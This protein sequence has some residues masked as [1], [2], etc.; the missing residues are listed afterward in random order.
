MQEAMTDEQ[1]ISA[2]HRSYVNAF[3]KLAEHCSNGAVREAGRTFAFVSGLSTPQ[4]NG[5]FVAQPVAVEHLVAALNW[6]DSGGLPYS[7]WLDEAV[8]DGLTPVAAERGLMRDAWPVPAMALHP[9]P[10]APL[11]APGVSVEPGLEPG[12]ADYVPHSMAEDSDVRLFTAYLDGRPVGSSIAIRCGEVSSVV[13]VG[14]RPEARR[15]GV[16]IAASW[17][18][19]EAG[20]VWGCK[21]VL[22]EATEMGFPLYV[23]MGFRTVTRYVGFT[24]PEGLPV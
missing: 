7:V 22:L 17:A 4:L 13:A 11:P 20:M 2:A 15:R 23:A 19:V 21:A 10:P 24:Y 3:R 12:V 18:A 1:L 8:A 9:I 5:C 6:L 14:T 16:G